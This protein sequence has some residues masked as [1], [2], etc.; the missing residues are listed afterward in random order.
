MKKRILFLMTDA[1]GGHRAAAMAVDE[2]IHHLYPDTYDT[3]IED[4]WKKHTPWPMNKLPDTYPWMTGPGIPMWKLLWLISTT[5]QPHK[6]VFPSVSPVLKRY[7]SG[8]FKKVKPDIIIS[9]HPLMNHIGLKLR[10]K[11]GLKDVPFVTVVTDM[12]SIHP[13]WICPQVNFCMVPTEPARELA[14]KWGIPPDKVMVVGQPVGLKFAQMK[15]EDKSILRQKLGLQPER[16]TLLV[17]GGGEGFGPLFEITRAIAQTVPQAQMMVVAGRNKALKE[18]L[19]GV[20]WEIPTRIYGFVNNM[21]ELMG[22]ANILVTKAGPGTISEAFIANLPVILSGYIPGQ[23][24]GNVTYVQEHRAGLLA[25]KPQEI[26]NL[27][28]EWMEPDNPSLQEMARNAAALAK[29]E[30]AL[31]IARKVCDL[32]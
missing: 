13:T 28:R 12:V 29:P 14:L 32:I 23:E 21:P 30:A 3:I 16:R 1:G 22:A 2:A 10:D 20:S 9:V 4:L 25:E 11:A 31:T 15:A 26:A 18:K 5:A 8:Y 17:V 7:I 27:V 19:E 24:T 6:V